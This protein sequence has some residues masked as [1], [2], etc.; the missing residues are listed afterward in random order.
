MFELKKK[1]QNQ[2]TSFK[3]FLCDVLSSSLHTAEHTYARLTF[4]VSPVD[5]AFSSKYL[6]Y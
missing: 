4:V 2:V 3:L 1:Q 5:N 6:A